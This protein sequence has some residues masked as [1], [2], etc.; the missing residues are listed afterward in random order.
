MPSYRAVGM[1]HD[2]Y[3]FS[4]LPDRAALRWPGGARVAFAVVLHLEHWELD[5]P[6]VAVRD[7]RFRDPFGDFRPDYRTYT[8]REYGNRV[9][10]FRMLDALYR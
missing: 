5:P 10:V 8:I 3:P 4:A 1:D 7:P 9:G 6:A 2:L